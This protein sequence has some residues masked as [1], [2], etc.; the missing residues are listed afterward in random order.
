L[1]KRACGLGLLCSGVLLG[2]WAQSAAAPPGQVSAPAA[3]PSAAVLS[4]LPALVQ[5]GQIGAGW[6]VVT[7]PQQKPPVTRFSTETVTDRPA[8]RIE[9]R[10]SYGNLV[11]EPAAGAVPGRLAWA[12]RVHQP[13][14][15][16]DVS[17]KTSDDLAAKV[18]LS[19]DLP[20][21]RVP[22][23]ERQLLRVARSRS[24]ENLPAATLCWVWGGSAT[25]GQ[26]LDSPY[27]RRLRYIVLRAQDDA[28]DTWRE[29]SRD[30]AADFRRAFG[31][32]A[33]VP[34]PVLAV[35]VGADADNTG[36]HSVAHLAA[37]RWWP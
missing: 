5:G 3:Q 21:A 11:F 30:V 23:V 18:C 36:A 16:S 33:A 12:W 24:G 34:P 7:L 6:R 35:I 2:A 32:E 37:L 15:A 20:L 29:E 31:D 19:F 4:M 27:T 13:V 14:P 9:A 26:L 22:F 10:A 8:L 17:S 1:L 28:L 25:A